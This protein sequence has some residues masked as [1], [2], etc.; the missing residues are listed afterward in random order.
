[1]KNK[2]YGEKLLDP[3]WQRK[4]LEILLAADFTCE[5]CGSKT[6]TLQVH[7]GYYEKGRMPW[8]Y[9]NESLLCLCDKCHKERQLLEDKIKRCLLFLILLN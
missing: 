7:H 3:R 2:S 8:G 6:E 5:A 4:R 9:D 1:M